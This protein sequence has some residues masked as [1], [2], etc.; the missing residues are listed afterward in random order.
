MLR[1]ATVSDLETVASWITSASDCERWAG[2]RVSFPIDLDSLPDA[3]GFTEAHSFSVCTEGDRLVA[4]GQL[5]E[6]PLNRGHLARL[7]VAPSARGNGHGEALVK[8]LIQKAHAASLSPVSLNVDR[9]N[10]PAVAL[11]LKLGFRDA[12]R[13]LDEPESANARYMTRR[14]DLPKATS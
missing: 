11:Y 8:A 4:F 10:G 2:W 3:I 1:P 14:D 12:M 5:V 7:I 9:S 6:K 13:P